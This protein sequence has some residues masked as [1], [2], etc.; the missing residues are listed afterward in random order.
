M[1][2]ILGNDAEC[3]KYFGMHAD[4]RIT[5]DDD[6]ICSTGSERACAFHSYYYFLFFSA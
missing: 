1:S 2:C 3:Q 5:R 6:V 4:G